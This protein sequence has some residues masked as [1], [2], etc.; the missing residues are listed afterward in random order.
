MSSRTNVTAIIPHLRG[1]PGCIHP[2][3][4]TAN[5][6]CRC[7]PGRQ[8]Q[9][10]HVADNI[11]HDIAQAARSTARQERTITTDDIVF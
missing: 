6:D 8:A 5:D 9:I 7:P 2:F 10:A 3:D 1:L 4:L 11:A